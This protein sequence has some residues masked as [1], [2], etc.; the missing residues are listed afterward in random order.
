[1]LRGCRKHPIV[2]LS[3]SA[4]SSPSA[5]QFMLTGN[6]SMTHTNDAGRTEKAIATLSTLTKPRHAEMYAINSY[7]PP[8]CLVNSRTLMG[9][10]DFSFEGKS[11]QPINV[12][13]V[14]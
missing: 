5:I 4:A 9:C 3:G 8:R 11:V 7:Q 14:L 2:V 12:L 6:I 1:M 13:S 10:A